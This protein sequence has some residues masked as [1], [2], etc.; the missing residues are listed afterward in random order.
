MVL[1][2]PYIK[3]EINLTTDRS[4]S[5]HPGDET[6]ST[7]KLRR[8]YFSYSFAVSTLEKRITDEK[9]K[10]KQIF[11]LPKICLAAETAQAQVYGMFYV[12]ELIQAGEGNGS[13]YAKSGKKILSN[14]SFKLV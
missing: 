7:F 3:E 12:L 11:L 2:V 8:N 9:N 4:P 13:S 5:L 6:S 10:M 1:Q 14:D